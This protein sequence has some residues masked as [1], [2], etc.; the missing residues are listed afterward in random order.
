MTL[1]YC[2]CLVFISLFWQ[3]VGLA[4]NSEQ[5]IETA[6]LDALVRAYPGFIKG[7]DDNNIFWIDGTTTS[8]G[9]DQKEL[10]LAQRLKSASILGQFSLK[11]P[12]GTMPEAPGIDADPGR[13]RNEQF[14]KKMYGDCRKGE[15]QSHLTTIRWLP[16]TW[17]AEVK[18]TN[19]NNVADQLVAVSEEIDRL[20]AAIKRAAYPIAGVLSCRPV[21]D[22]GKMSMHAYGA[23]ID[24]NLA[25]SDYWFWQPKKA[26][27]KYRNRMP[28][29]IVEIFERHG[30]IWGGKWYHFDTMHFEYRPELL[31]I[32][33]VSK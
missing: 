18:V 9:P 23:A 6:P 16:K 2:A 14:F 28:Y 8:V 19:I 13:F 15:V 5:R 26:P 30:F 7:H 4:E 1:R 20:P 24:L 22:T 33:E 29:E 3:S 25:F 12:P 10:P 27:I 21:A 31:P 11:Y 17:N 32:R